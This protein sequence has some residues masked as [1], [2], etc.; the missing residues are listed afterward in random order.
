MA[1][2]KWL[3]HEV[4]ASG[5]PGRGGVGR[6]AA[7]GVTD[8]ITLQRGDEV[9]GWLAAE[10]GALEVGA[11]M[12]WHRL[13]LSGKW[14]SAAQD[15]G[16]LEA[17]VRWARTMTPSERE[18]ARVVVHCSAGL[19]RTGVALYMM[20]RAVGLSQ[21]EALARIAQTRALTAQE[22][23]LQSKRHGRLI[24]LAEACFVALP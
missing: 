23:C 21:E 17:L 22:L 7:E 6:W 2:V 14:L 24:D 3:Q 11:G 20:F 5:A 10:V 1:W 16:S 19:H 15:Q 13:P 12:R 9:A 18:S 8:L 4:C